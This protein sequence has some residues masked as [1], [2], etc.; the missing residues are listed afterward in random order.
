MQETWISRGTSL[1]TI[2]QAI[3]GTGSDARSNCRTTFFSQYWPGDLSTLSSVEAALLQDLLWWGP[4]M[5]SRLEQLA[6][7]D[8]TSD[9]IGGRDVWSE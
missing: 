2:F 5:E 6:G 7:L 1:L 3:R 4:L 9:G 8:A